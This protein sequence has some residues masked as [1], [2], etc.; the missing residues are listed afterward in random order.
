MCS[1]DLVGEVAAAVRNSSVS[2]HFGLYYSLLEFYHPIYMQDRNNSYETSEF[3]QNK[4]LPEMEDMVLRYEPEIIWPDGEWD[5]DSSYWRSTD[6]L[7]WLYNDSPVKDTVVVNDRWGIETRN[8]HGGFWTGPDRLN[9][10]VLLPHKWENCFTLDRISWGWRAT[11]TIDD[12]MSPEELIRTII[13]TVACGGNALVNVGPMKDGMIPL[14]QQERLLQMGEWLDLNGDAIYGAVPYRVQN[15]TITPGVWYTKN[16]DRRQVYAIVAEGWPGRTLRL[17]SMSV[18]DF[19]T[20]ELLGNPGRTLEFSAQP[21]GI[22]LTM[23]LLEDV[24]SKWAYTL[25]FNV[26]SEK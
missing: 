26:F 8:E 7:A 16:A 22:L 21:E 9:P 17:G 23:P 2:M 3:V 12:Y 4:M 10:G 25:V 15:D 18:F 5:T 13:E 6:F 11:A 24:R 14:I 1:S 19:S 20:I